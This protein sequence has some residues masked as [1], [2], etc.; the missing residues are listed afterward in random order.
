MKLIRSYMCELKKTIDNLPIKDVEKVAEIIFNA[1]SN[2][3]QIFIIG[4]GGSASTASHFSCDLNKGTLK[5][6]YDDDEKRLR[7]ISLT[8]NVSLLTAYGNDLGYDDIFSQQ[9]KNLVNKGD[10]L[11]AITGSGNSRN[12]LK[13][14]EAAKK[15]KAT[16]I[17]ILGFKGGKAKEIVDY[18]IIVPSE[19]YGRIEDVQM[20]LA[21]VISN[22]VGEMKEKHD[23]HGK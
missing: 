21:H 11:I 4:N 7:V 20:I 15:A 12:I 10:V 1:Y 8:D 19:H 6:V 16:V 14:I 23:C 3:K 13:G 22:Y 9:L 18:C 2:D 5:R 17:G